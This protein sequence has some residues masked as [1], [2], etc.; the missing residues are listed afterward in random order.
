MKLG[1]VWFV[2][3]LFAAGCSSTISAADYDQS[4]VVDAD[5]AVVTEGDKCNLDR[6]NCGNAAINASAR[7][8]Y[9][10]DVAALVCLTPS[11]SS[12][13]CLCEQVTSVTCIEGTCAFG[14][15]GVP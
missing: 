7:A 11:L 14:A 9:E 12:S 2:A 5:C 4:C 13:A 10:A 8:D 15:V 3:A 6:C 1:L